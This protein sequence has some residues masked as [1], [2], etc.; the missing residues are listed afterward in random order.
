MTPRQLRRVE[1][2]A[3]ALLTLFVLG[4]H[5][6]R[7]RH[8]GALWRD[9]VAALNV[10]TLP[11]VSEMIE[12]F[13]HEAFPVLFPL[14]LR[15]AVALSGSHDLAL[16]IWGFG[17]G[18]LQ[19]AALWLAVRWGRRGV[20]LAALTLVGLNSAVLLFGD[21]LRGYGL[22]SALVVLTLGLVARAL[23]Q[24]SPG[25]LAAAGICAAAAAH[26]LFPAS[27]LLLAIGLGGAV[28]AWLSGRGRLAWE[29]VSGGAVIALSLLVYYVPLEEARDWDIVARSPLPA[30]ALVH[31]LRAAVAPGPAFLGWAWLAALVLA[32]TSLWYLPPPRFLGR[33]PVRIAALAAFAL[34]LLT[35]VAFLLVL[36]YDPRPWYFLPLIAL[37]AVALDLFGGEQRP[38]KGAEEETDKAS[39]G[40]VVIRLTR[41][42]GAV[43]LA[44]LLAPSLE[45]ASTLRET[46]IDT[47]AT[48]VSD[49][50]VP[51]DLVLVNPWNCGVSFARYYRGPAAW[52]TLPPIADHRFHRY[53]LLKAQ[54]ASA[55]PLDELLAAMGAALR[56]GHR[57]W[58][59]GG[60]HLSRHLAPVA[61]LPPAPAGKW[62]WFDVPYTENWSR[63]VGVFLQLRAASWQGVRL[64]GG[65]PINPFERLP[66]LVVS[67]WRSDE[68]VAARA[69][70]TL[71]SP[72]S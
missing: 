43:V 24:P 61:P 66:L 8:A 68:E 42:I 28:A 4:L 58:L 11:T 36:S 7:L 47:L 25:R 50:A 34:G 17:I 16:R 29:L 30:S 6:N 12:A 56:A 72:H 9:E 48:I 35:M 3:A 20:P 10:A 31:A 22:G 33:D 44:A 59:V 71:R 23:G 64:E 69:A 15:G 57:V 55:H 2:A 41:A 53:D 21:T 18:V 19:V 62:G 45:R 70:H 60:I 67:G 38:E 37:A 51:G 46:N 49:D 13:P 14:A 39:R 32:G 54:M 27:P 1:A 65:D 5:F 26:T 40:E 63:Q 52:T